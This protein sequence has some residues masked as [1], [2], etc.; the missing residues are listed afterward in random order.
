[1]VYIIEERDNAY[2]GIYLMVKDERL[3]EFLVKLNKNAKYRRE[4]LDNPVETLLKEG[5]YVDERDKIRIINA[6]DFLESDI[7]HI[8]KIPLESRDYLEEIEFRVK[9]TYEGSEIELNE[10][11]DI[12]KVT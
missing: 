8:F 2:G 5:F 9:M 6:V 11:I 7:L 4:F 1:M 10:D 12:I 3:K